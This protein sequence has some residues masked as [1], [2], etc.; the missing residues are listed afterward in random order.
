M[1]I[2]AFVMCMA[3]ERSFFEINVDM[4]DFKW[5]HIVLGTYNSSPMRSSFLVTIYNLLRNAN[6]VDGIFF[7]C[8]QVVGVSVSFEELYRKFVEISIFFLALNRM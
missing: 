6:F 4:M 5:F 7:P 8:T 1:S 3:S 2:V